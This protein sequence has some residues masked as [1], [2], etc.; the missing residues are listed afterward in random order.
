MELAV[1]PSILDGIP[2][3]NESCGALKGL[4]KMLIAKP[5]GSSYWCCLCLVGSVLLGQVRLAGGCFFTPFFCCFVVNL[6]NGFYWFY[7]R[8]GACTGHSKSAVGVANEPNK[9][10]Q[11]KLLNATDDCTDV[12]AGQFQLNTSNPWDN[13]VKWYRK[14]R[15]RMQIGPVWVSL[16]VQFLGIKK[17]SFSCCFFLLFPSTLSCL[18]GNLLFILA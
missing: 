1:S 17:L 7:W 15:K 2:V 3:E 16:V 9:T 18:W 4:S 11:P 13:L 10:N 5:G 6:A 12:C 14:C 8:M